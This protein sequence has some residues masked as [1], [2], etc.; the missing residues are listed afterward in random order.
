M[1]KIVSMNRHKSPISPMHLKRHAIFTP[2]HMIS[3]WEQPGTTKIVYNSLSYCQVV[4]LLG[5]SLIEFWRVR[6][7][8][9]L[10]VRWS[11]PMIGLRK[12]HKM[13]VMDDGPTRIETY[14][15]KYMGL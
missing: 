11:D 14:H 9:E 4:S 3:V 10:T 7:E 2:I 15:T 5:I 13:K 6:G 12:M 8:F 1:K